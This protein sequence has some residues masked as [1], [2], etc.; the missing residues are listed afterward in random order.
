MVGLE[1]RV[2]GLLIAGLTT[3]AACGGST[4]HPAAA[5]RAAPAGWRQAMRV[6]QVVDITAGRSDKRMV[7]AA[8]GSLALLRPGGRLR[9]FA[10]GRGGYATNRGPEPSIALARGQAGARGGAR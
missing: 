10:R 4:A 8:N 3:L 2:L 6:K 1:N 5:S 7:V 9:G